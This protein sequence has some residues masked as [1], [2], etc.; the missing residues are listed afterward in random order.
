MATDISKIQNLFTSQVKSTF[1]T[2]RIVWEK[3][4]KNF[5][6]I[7]NIYIITQVPNIKL[8]FMSESMES[9]V[10]QILWVSFKFGDKNIPEHIFDVKIQ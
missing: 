10:F 8:V 5:C 3:S 6:I 1:R 2:M 9:P 4:L 7:K